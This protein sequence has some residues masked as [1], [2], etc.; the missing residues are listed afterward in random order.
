MAIPTP[1]NTNMTDAQI[2]ASLAHYLLV[3][4]P[5]GVTAEQVGA[6]T[7][8][9]ING[10]IEHGVAVGNGTD[11]DTLTDVGIYRVTSNAGGETMVNIPTKCAGVLFT[12]SAYTN[13]GTRINQVWIPHFY[14]LDD[15]AYN[16]FIRQKASNGWYAWCKLGDTTPTKLADGTDLNDLPVRDAEYYSNSAAASATMINTPFTS[17]SFRLEVKRIISN[18]I[19]QILYPNDDVGNCYYQRMLGASGWS[20]WYKFEGVQV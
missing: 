17:A 1:L 7:K 16:V 8:E 18:R 11:F 20:S 5:H 14:S 19:Y 12:F 4:N 15:T 6:Y 3:N 2:L 10:K 13:D 9:Y